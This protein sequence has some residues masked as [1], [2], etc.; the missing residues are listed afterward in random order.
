MFLFW[1]IIFDNLF[2]MVKGRFGRSW[3][4]NLP[5]YSFAAIGC[6]KV[7]ANRKQLVFFT[8][9]ISGPPHYFRTIVKNEYMSNALELGYL[10]GFTY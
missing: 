8:V 6:F 9:L 2:Q 7:K 5:A 10:H 3:P 1:W 4:H